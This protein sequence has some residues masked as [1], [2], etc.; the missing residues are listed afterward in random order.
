MASGRVPKVVE[1]RPSIFLK[2]VMVSDEGQRIS[3][4]VPRRLLT[5]TRISRD[6]DGGE[7]DVLV[8]VAAEEPCRDRVGFLVGLG[9]AGFFSFSIL[10]RRTGEAPC[11]DLW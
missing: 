11:A 4:R 9:C 2:S 5:E 3:T 6:D 1:T 8:P 7:E 10:D